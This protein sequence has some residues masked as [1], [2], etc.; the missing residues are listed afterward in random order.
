MLW[1]SLTLV[2]MDSLV[3]VYGVQWQYSK[4]IVLLECLLPQ[5]Q[6]ELGLEHLHILSSQKVETTRDDV[7]QA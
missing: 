3:E 6:K 2:T 7:Q 1:D 5:Q 4:A